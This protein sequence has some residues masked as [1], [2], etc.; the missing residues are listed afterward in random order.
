[1]KWSNDNDLILNVYETKDLIEDCRK[2]RNLK[3][4]IMIN[5]SAVEQVN[6]YKFLGL[7]VMNTLSWTQI[8]DK[9]IKKGRQKLFFLRILKSCNVDINVMIIFIV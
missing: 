5:N 6:I 4:S 9:I 7:T 3:D 2:C 8:A 1:M